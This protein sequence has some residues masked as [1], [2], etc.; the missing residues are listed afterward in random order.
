MQYRTLK[1]TGETVS[2]L[3]FGCMRFPTVQI[4]S[5]QSIDE[6]EAIKMLRYAIDS[7]VNYIDTA[8][9]YHEGQSELLVGKALRDGYREKVKLATKSPSFSIHAEGDFDRI[10]EEQLEKLQVDQ[11]DFYLQHCLDKEYW[12]D[13]V[14]K[15]GILEKL[16]AAKAAG[17]I[18]HI[19]FSFHDDLETFKKIVDGFDGWE[20][21]QIQLNYADTRFQAGIEGL[22]Y[23]AVNGLD[24][25]VM[26]PLRGGRLA[27]PAPLVAKEL[28]AAKSPVE[29]GLDFLWDRPEV[30]TVLSGMSTM[31]QIEQN[32]CYADR[33]EPGMLSQTERDMLYAAGDAFNNG[34]L[35]SCT[36]CEYCM[37]CPAGLNIPELFRAYNMTATYGMNDARQE[38]NQL[39]TKPDSCVACKK[40]E[41]ACPQS[42]P[43]SELMPVI[44]QAFR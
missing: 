18:R 3:G 39:E 23:A 14:H 21:C 38:Y 5:K 28:S 1:N 22:E 12:K 15:F 26:E 19:G 35:V 16:Q 32:L 6:P 9:P 10:L 25:I 11:I 36:K 30:G 42:I 31:E 29:W 20:F 8:Y 37:P 44:A 13:V 17:K 43:V 4:D 33:A 7:G 40:C 24:V 27:A 2:V 41:K 34:T